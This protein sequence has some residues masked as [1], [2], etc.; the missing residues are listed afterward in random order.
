MNSPRIPSTAVIVTYQSAPYIG[1][2][3]E[4]LQ[5]ERE[6]GLDLEVIVVDNASTDG[7]SGIVARFEWARFV[8]SGGNLGY[9][10]GVNIGSRLVPGNRALFVLNP[11]LV[12]MPGALARLLDDLAEP[13]VGVVV[14]RVQDPSGTLVPSLRYEPSNWRKLIDAMFGAQAARLADG[15]S[16]MVWN[17][18]AYETT[19]YPDWAV[20]A[21]LLVS[22]ECRAAVGAW[23]ERYFLYFEETDFMRRVRES[24]F[25]IRYDPAA[26]VRHVMGGS[27]TSDGLYALGYVNGARYYRRFHGRVSSSIFTAGIALHMLARAWRSA[28]RLGFRALVSRRVRAT[29]PGPSR[30]DGRLLPDQVMTVSPEAGKRC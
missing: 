3:L 22:T 16:G 17:P 4:S 23:D 27:G 20:G 29:L 28:D 14:P 24:G 5:A 8:D 19:Q 26:V 10:A 15:W 12:V 9:A 11:D 7:T 18:L 25:L 1:A 30:R 13:S 2:L 6:A 21:A